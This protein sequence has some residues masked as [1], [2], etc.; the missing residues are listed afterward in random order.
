MSA[1]PIACAPQKRIWQPSIVPDAPNLLPDGA[2]RVFGTWRN[3]CRTM[4]SIFTEVP[5]KRLLSSPRV[6]AYRKFCRYVSSS[7][8]FDMAVGDRKA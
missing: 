4:P 8:S 5:V 6:T 3:S 2:R 1:M 7:F